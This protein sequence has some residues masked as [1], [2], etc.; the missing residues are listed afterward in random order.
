MGFFELLVLFELEALEYASL[1][2]LFDLSDLG[3]FDISL[4]TVFNIRYLH[5]SGVSPAY[6][7][8]MVKDV[9]LFWLSLSSI[10]DKCCAVCQILDCF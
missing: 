5:V 10:F 3:E 1:S 2:T 9:P 6:A 7:L 4:F 8:L